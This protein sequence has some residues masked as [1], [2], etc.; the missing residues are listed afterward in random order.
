VALDVDGNMNWILTP[1]Q[2]VGMLV[3][4]FGFVATDENIPLTRGM[5]IVAIKYIGNLSWDVRVFCR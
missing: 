2:S 1:K 4:L 5:I 3:H